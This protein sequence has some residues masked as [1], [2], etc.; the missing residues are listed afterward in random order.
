MSR[1]SVDVSSARIPVL[2]V[3]YQGENE[4]TDVLFDI[5]SWITE[6]GEGVAQLR[7]KR[8]GNSEEES[9]V[10]SLTITDGKAVWTVSETDTANK[11]NGKVQLSYMVGNI[12]KKAVI[13]PYKVG[14]SI[15]GADNPVDP[16][17]S[18][19]ERSKAWAIGETLD[20]DAVPETDETYQNNAKYYAEQ[21]D[22]LGSAQV[23]LAAEK[24]T[25]AAEQVTLATEKAD[26][27]AASEAAVNG[28]STQLTT[29]M[30][31]IET[32]QAV[33]DARMDTFTSLPEGST[34][35]N[36]ELA[37]IRV[38]ADGT[39]YDTAGNAVRGQIGELKS[40]LGDLIGTQETVIS[41][42]N[43]V[44]GTL[45]NFPVEIKKGDI[46]EISISTITKAKSVSVSFSNNDESLQY[47][48]KNYVP[49]QGELVIYTKIVSDVN[50]SEVIV[51]FEGTNADIN[52]KRFRNSDSIIGE[53]L[54]NQSNDISQLVKRLDFS[55]ENNILEDKL[56]DTTLSGVKKQGTAFTFNYFKLRTSVTSLF[57][58]F[59]L[60]K[61]YYTIFMWTN[62]YTERKIYFTLQDENGL[63]SYLSV[64]KEKNDAVLNF[65]LSNDTTITKAGFYV[66]GE[67]SYNYNGT[68]NVLL[69]SGN[70][71]TRDKLTIIE[72]N[73]NEIT[74]ITENIEHRL[75]TSEVIIDSDVDNNVLTAFP[76]DISVGDV[77]E[78]KLELFSK[79]RQIIV[80]IADE[81]G[82][83]QFVVNYGAN[84]IPV[85]W[86]EKIIADITSVMNA[87]MFKVYIYGSKAKL[88]INKLTLGKID[89]EIYDAKNRIS[90]IEET[91]KFSKCLVWEDDFDLEYLDETKWGFELGNNRPNNNELQFYTRNNISFEDSC[92]VITAKREEYKGFHWTSSSITTMCKKNVRFGRIEAKMK[93][94][95]VR[96]SFPAF[97]MIGQ[98]LVIKYTEDSDGNV[99]K[100]HVRGDYPACGEL[101]IIE[102]FGTGDVASGEWGTDGSKHHHFTHSVDTT[103]FHLYA[104]EWND[105]EIK[106]FVDDVLIGTSSIADDRLK[107]YREN[108]FYIIVN[109][110]V[111][112]SAGT[113]DE[114]T[115]IIKMYVD[116]VRVYSI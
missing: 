110:A 10:L 14:K 95:N 102:Q 84:D 17:D 88:K 59:K 79:P 115:N 45:H 68:I 58:P 82:N 104:I 22:I 33:Q 1:I 29:R 106:Y 86:N 69:V 12:V 103:E 98:P 34:S 15:V 24:V 55:E 112:G 81:D 63:N 100:T 116:W 9:Y 107:A 57:S 36:A 44:S 72:S 13:Y 83:E 48:Y 114:S 4:V 109:L 56:F 108:A 49:D 54:N 105:E 43:R 28:V 90:A 101:D 99:T 38:G 71:S 16:F 78:F 21:A 91:Q 6:F 111:G 8:P 11:G 53:Q 85:D 74:K 62:D 92:L 70:Y 50:A 5:S 60:S 96:G 77:F 37:D 51:Y 41:E 32:E 3:G 61:G 66:Y 75:G 80:K 40:D 46:F 18:W 30:S 94:A 73:I 42:K 35:G 52:V 31:A 113:P 76:Y 20:G 89:L 97:W 27:A 87:T 25:L 64:D 2:Q 67:G 65:E 47:V 39:T 26:A 7:V 93:L 23:V 19:I